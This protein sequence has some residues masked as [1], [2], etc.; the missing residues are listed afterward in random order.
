M[1]PEKKLILEVVESVQ[2]GKGPSLIPDLVKRF[3]EKGL[4]PERVPDLLQE[5]VDEGE[6]VEVEYN[7]PMENVNHMLKSIYLPKGTKARLINAEPL[8]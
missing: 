4:P 6:L 8:N 1:S 2:G 7:L 3:I 5:L